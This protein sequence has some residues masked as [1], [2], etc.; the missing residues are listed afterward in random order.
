MRWGSRPELFSRWPAFRITSCLRVFIL[1]LCCFSGLQAQTFGLQRGTDIFRI[2]PLDELTI[3]FENKGVRGD[4]IEM[5]IRGKL[6]NFKKDSLYMAYDDFAIHNYYHKAEDSLHYVDEVLHDT[7]L[8]MKVPHNQINGIYWHR[9][10]LKSAMTKV[11]FVTLGVG[12]ATVPFVLAMKPSPA[13]DVITVTNITAAATML[14]A[15][16][17]GIIFS[18]KKFWIRPKNNKSW[19]VVP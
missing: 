3:F 17:V 5:M 15:A 19:N 14:T 13:R 6:L 2:K 8:F 16:A 7:M 1:I 9:T 4:S 11:V 10:Q 12:L 18:K